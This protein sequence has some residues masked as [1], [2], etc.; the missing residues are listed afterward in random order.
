MNITMKNTLTKKVAVLRWWLS[1]EGLP[2]KD[3]GSTP[4]L[5]DLTCRRAAKP[6]C[7]NYCTCMLQ[8]LQP[9]CPWACALQQESSPCSPQ[10]EKSPN[11]ARQ[12]STAKNK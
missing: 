11:A 10:L 3:A 4:V 9:K 8:L 1:G 7:P 6:V 5:E 12:P 2:A